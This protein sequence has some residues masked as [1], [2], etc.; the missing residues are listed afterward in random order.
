MQ[1]KSTNLIVDAGNTL[2]KVVEVQGDEVRGLEVYNLV[3]LKPEQIK[4]KIKSFF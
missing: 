4:K 1:E 3:D 2:V